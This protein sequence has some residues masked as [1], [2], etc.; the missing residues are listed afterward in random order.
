[1]SVGP[2]SSEW[3]GHLWGTAPPT[4]QGWGGVNL[5]PSPASKSSGLWPRPPPRQASVF[6]STQRG[7]LCS[8]SG[9]SQTSGT[10]LMYLCVC[11]PHT[12]LQDPLQKGQ[13]HRLG[14]WGI[15]STKKSKRANLRARSVT[16]RGLALTLVGQR[17]SVAPLGPTPQSVLTATNHPVPGPCNS[18]GSQGGSRMVP[19]S[20]FLGLH[21]QRAPL[22]ASAHPLSCTFSTAETPS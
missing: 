21:S 2:R 20:V 12:R 15:W 1:M 18:G 8:R 22:G 6:V 16:S 19:A 7:S 14:L 4:R 13:G 11:P 10:C 5:S 9:V 17:V 3:I